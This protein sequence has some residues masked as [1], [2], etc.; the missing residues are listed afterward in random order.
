VPALSPEQCL[1]RL[2]V[3]YR[4]AH[5]C[6]P[7]SDQLVISWAANPLLWAEYQIRHYGWSFLA[8]EAV[9]RHCRS[10]VKRAI[11]ALPQEPA[12]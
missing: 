1:G 8:T 7:A 2:R 6:E 4:D 5:K 12:A 9:V 10:L 11:L 3:L